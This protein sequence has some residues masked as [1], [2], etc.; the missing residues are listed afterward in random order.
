MVGLWLFGVL[1][2]AFFSS[3]LAHA[4]G[5]S[6]VVWLLAGLLFGPLGLVVG[7]FPV[8]QRVLDAREREEKRRREAFGGI[9]P[10]RT[11]WQVVLG[12]ASVLAVLV[13]L[14]TLAS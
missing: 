12:M 5:R 13:A 7:L 4:R 2:F 8:N 1:V 11:E 3:A 10:V 6:A 9:D 14:A